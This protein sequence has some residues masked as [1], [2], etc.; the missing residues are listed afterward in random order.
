M[1]FKVY[2]FYFFHSSMQHP[3][4]GNLWFKQFKGEVSGVGDMLAI[5]QAPKAEV[6]DRVVAS[7]QHIDRMTWHCIHGLAA[8]TLLVI[9]TSMSYTNHHP[10][11]AAH[12]CRW[13]CRR[14]RMATSFS[15][16]PGG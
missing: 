8:S 14:C 1:E 16:S 7:C 6:Q 5:L 15:C 4:M 10:V 3:R 13:N 12:H 11:A 2:R 9:Y